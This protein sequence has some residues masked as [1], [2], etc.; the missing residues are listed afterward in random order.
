MARSSRKGF[1]I[2]GDLLKKVL[3]HKSNN[4]KSP[5]KTWSRAST[6]LPNMVGLTISVHNGHKHIPV[7]ITENMVAHKLGEFALT[8]TYRGHADA[9]KVKK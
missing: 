3:D 4:K 7:I 6:I 5:I 9:K 8:R 1:Y 2:A